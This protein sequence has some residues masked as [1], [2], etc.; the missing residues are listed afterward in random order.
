VLTVI[1]TIRGMYIGSVNSY[2]DNHGDVY[3]LS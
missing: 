3:K 1:V 2:C